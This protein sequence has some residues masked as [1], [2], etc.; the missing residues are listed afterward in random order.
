MIEAPR[1]TRE[2]GSTHARDPRLPESSPN[3]LQRNNFDLLRLIF[4]SIVCLVH[5]Y[6]LSGFRQLSWIAK[7]FSS[8]VAVK[9]FF[10]VSGF[11]IFLSYDRSKSWGGYAEKRIR[12]IYPAYFTVVTFT[13]VSL[14][15]IS[16]KPLS[17]YFSVVWLKYL[18][19]NLSFLNFLQ[20]TVPG[21]FESNK[22][23]AVNG[24]LWTLKIEVMFYIAVP[25]FSMLF[26]RF[27]RWPTLLATYCGSVLYVG[28]CE[29]LA[30]RT[31]SG[32]YRELVN[33]LPGQ[34]SYFMTGAALYY[35]R[36][37]LEKYVRYL[38]VAAILILLAHRSTSLPLFEPAA[39]GIVVVVA[40]LYFHLGNF[41]KYGDFSYGVY[42][43]HFPMI[44]LLIDRG[45][46]QQNPGYFL[47]ATVTGTLFGA[48]LL[49]HGVEKRFL[50]RHSH[51]VE[52]STPV[53]AVN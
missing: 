28:F 52:A 3:R 48:V 33:Q 12:R 49:W 26:R 29:V 19:A 5:A 16:S 8:A 38:A 41:G 22:L 7:A 25:F 24:A 36:P 51:Y 13:A 53:S 4:A 9:G 27:G 44:Q 23:A 17:D 47:A 40:A 11:L 34:L 39:L 10:V 2:P 15:A 50:P 6:Q 1:F 31:G 14:A 30:Q 37:W 43:L 45:W 35:Y 21:V 32:L 42:I 18:A 46:F 20:L